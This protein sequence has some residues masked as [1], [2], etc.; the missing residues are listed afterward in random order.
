MK[1]CSLST[2][3]LQYTI[4]QLTMILTPESIDIPTPTWNQNTCQETWK[5][6]NKI[7]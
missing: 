7:I 3:I 2:H 5:D 6:P 1:D 4:L